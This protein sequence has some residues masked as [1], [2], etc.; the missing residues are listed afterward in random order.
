[1]EVI[2]A[3]N[4]IKE[5]TLEQEKQSF[6]K[7]CKAFWCGANVI[8]IIMIVCVSILA[9]CLIIGVAGG[10]ADSGMEE[11]STAGGMIAVASMCVIATGYIIALGFGAKIFKTLRDGETPF[12]YDIADKLKGAGYVMMVTGGLGFVLNVVIQCLKANG[13]EGIG[14]AIELPDLIPFVFGSFLVALAYVFNYGCKL[15]QESDETL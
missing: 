8:R 14:T 9:L 10:A 1:M 13:V 11:F 12:R 7:M 6:M 15:Q 2:M 3:K 5:R 4:D